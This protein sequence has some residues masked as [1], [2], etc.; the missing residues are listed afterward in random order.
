MLEAGGLVYHRCTVDSTADSGDISAAVEEED[1]CL[2][3]GP[4]EDVGRELSDINLNAVYGTSFDQTLPLVI[5]SSETLSVI[6]VEANAEGTKFTRLTVPILSEFIESGGTELR[7]SG[8]V[9]VG[10]AQNRRLD[11]GNGE[12]AFF[13]FVVELEGM[14]E[15]GCF[16]RVHK[17]IKNVF[18]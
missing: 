8:D 2:C 12:R 15:V 18:F 17:R 1:F 7:L 14:K 4:E 3:I 10:F 6:S 13:E 5:G 9:D 11:E 16:S